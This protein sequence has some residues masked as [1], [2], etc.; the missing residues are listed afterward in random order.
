VNALLLAALLGLS[1]VQGQAGPRWFGNKALSVGFSY[2]SGFRIEA[3]RNNLTG[4]I[5][6]VPEAGF[7]FEF[8]SGRTVSSSDF[9]LDSIS[10]GKDAEGKVLNVKLR[11]ADPPLSLKLCY[12]AP[13]EGNWIEQRMSLSCAS[14]GL[15]LSRITHAKW[16]IAGAIGPSG[17]G[18][19]IPATGYPIGCGQVVFFRSFF[20]AVAHPAAEN[21]CSK[22]WVSCSIPA[23]IRLRSG[24]LYSF[25]PFL[26]GAGREG[27]MRRAFHRCLWGL[28][29]RP[30]RMIFLVNDWYWKD[31]SR[32]LEDLKKFAAVKQKT[33]VPIDSFTLDDGW[34]TYTNK[35]AGLWGAL[36]ESRF[37]C[38]WEDLSAAGRKADIGVSLWFGPIGGYGYRPRRLPLARALGYEINGDKLCL[39]G[40]KYRKYVEEVFSK[41]A[42]RGMDYIKVD[43]FWPDCRKAGHGHPTGPGG[44]PAR[45]DALAEVF[46]AWLRAKPDLRIAYTSGSNPSPFWLLHAD[47]L[48]RGGA[49]DAFLGK[50]EPIDRYTT[51]IDACLWRLRK[52][53]VPI[54]AFVTFDLVTRR[55]LPSSDQA[56]SRGFWWL[57][58][59][60][61]LHH[62]WYVHPDDLSLSQWRALARA[63]TWARS[64]QEVFRFGRMIG[65]EVRKGEIYGFAAFNGKAGTLAFRNPSLQEKKI[66]GELAD[67]LELDRS[68]ASGSYLLEAVFGRTADVLG[69][70]TGKERL[71]LSLPPLGIAVFEVQRKKR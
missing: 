41:W 10:K 48:W 30:E 52:T 40:R 23:E 50:G 63:A 21:F 39:A 26:I 45:M 29:G 6:E 36:L 66:A 13:R 67:W 18:Q 14:R 62:D 49:D 53:C 61:S 12:K 16:K 15:K 47:Y 35:E 68:E 4:E 3:L 24:A 20:C 37:S 59:R 2:S 64:H 43:G 11:S 7:F 27:A 57:A 9:V 5:L 51:Y 44:A 71:E 42:K 33:G 46:S 58:A 17:P 55:I 54:G 34:S 56:L 65:G 19:V 8:S 70:H 31:K 28:R 60:T 22:E 69:V 1:T 32:T 38:T 25:Q